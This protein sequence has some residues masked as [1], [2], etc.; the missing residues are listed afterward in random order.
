TEVGA[1]PLDGIL[2]N[3][4]WSQ[5]VMELDYRAD[6]LVLHRPGTL[7]V[8]KRS[9]PLFFDGSHIYAPITVTTRA[10]PPHTDRVVVQ[11]DTGAS[12]LLI[13]GQHERRFEQDYTEGLEPIYGIGAAE[14]MPPSKFFQVTRRIPVASLEIGG[15]K[16]TTV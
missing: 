10:D 1:I 7:R 5:F 8:P 3:N 9:E 6:R 2:G 12:G 4:V 15:R 13:A 16:V 14:L 11:V